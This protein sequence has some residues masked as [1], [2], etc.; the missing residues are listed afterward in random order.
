MQVYPF[1]FLFHIFLIKTSTQIYSVCLQKK[2]WNAWFFKSYILFINSLLTYLGKVLW[3][4]YCQLVCLF[5]IHC[6][7]KSRLG[8]IINHKL[9]QTLLHLYYNSATTLLQ[10]CYTL[11]QFCY[12]SLQLCHNS[13]TT[14]QSSKMSIFYKEQQLQIKFDPKST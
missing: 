1:C 13:A 9:P 10:L 8:L 6:A 2:L 14:D 11:L 4:C 3:K 12:N 7:A 5:S